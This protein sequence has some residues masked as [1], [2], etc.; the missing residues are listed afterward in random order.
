MIKA[1]SVFFTAPTLFSSSALRKGMVPDTRIIQSILRN[2]SPK[3]SGDVFVVFEPNRFI[4]D[5][6]GLTV[7]TTHGSP[8]RYDTYVPIMFAGNGIPAQQIGRPVETVDVAPTLS[9]LLG[10]KP[11]SGAVGVVLEELLRDR[12]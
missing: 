6:E 5:F 2:Y 12:H 9:I 7:A 8:W 4:N 10:A 11:P 1:F 3:R